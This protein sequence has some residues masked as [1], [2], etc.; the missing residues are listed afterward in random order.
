MHNSLKDICPKHCQTHRWNTSSVLLHLICKDPVVKWKPDPCYQCK[1]LLCWRELDNRGCIAW[2]LARKMRKP[3]HMCAGQ[4][5]TAA[6]S[7]TRVCQWGELTHKREQHYT[8]WWSW[9][10]ALTVCLL[11]TCEAAAAFPKR[12]SDAARK[13]REQGASMPSQ[14]SQR[15]PA[16]TDSL[17]IPAQARGH[18]PWPGSS[19][20]LA[21]G[22]AKCLPNPSGSGCG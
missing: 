1:G 8:G 14:L 3:L 18:G 9:L 19:A 4:S 7:L 16:A 5:L 15:R 6:N 22:A 21:A 13:R 11:P 17:G 10:P 20:L 12:A 2:K